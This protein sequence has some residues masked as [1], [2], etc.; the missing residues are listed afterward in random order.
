MDEP[1]KVVEEVQFDRRKLPALIMGIVVVCG[2]ACAWLFL[3]LDIFSLI[4]SS[5]LPIPNVTTTGTLQQAA[6]AAITSTSVPTQKPL[7]T[8]TLALPTRTATP[9]QRV[10]NPANQHLYLYVQIPLLWHEARDYCVSQGGYLATIQTSAENRFVYDLATKYNTEVGTWLGGTDEAEEGTWVWVTGEPWKYQDW[11]WS[12]PLQAEPDNIRGDP[13][14][15]ST[16]PRIRGADYLT[17]DS[18]D[19]TWQD[20][21]DGEKY[22]VCEWEP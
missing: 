13:A 20:W 8:S 17:F 7:P 16:E 1:P 6:T 10:L 14:N 4:S 11:I 2:L 21:D 3:G 9:D 12:P 19:R 5:P 15:A 22:F 18:W